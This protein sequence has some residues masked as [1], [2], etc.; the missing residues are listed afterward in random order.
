MIKIKYGW[1]K[2]L[3]FSLLCVALGA[4]IIKVTQPPLPKISPPTIPLSTKA[5]ITNDNQ[6]TA[7]R[8][9]YRICFQYPHHYQ[10]IEAENMFVWDGIVWF[11]DMEGNTVKAFAV[12]CIWKVTRYDVGEEWTSKGL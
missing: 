2:Q 3:L 1:L 9:T 12:E 4:F 7:Q 6:L 5:L 10:Y 11:I 8:T